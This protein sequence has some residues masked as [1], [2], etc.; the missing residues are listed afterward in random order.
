MASV[1]VATVERLGLI[2]LL[3]H[4]HAVRRSRL[5]VPSRPLGAERTAHPPGRRDVEPIGI[6]AIL[7][8]R[9]L[10]RLAM[11]RG[12]FDE[13]AQRLAPLAPLA[14]RATDIQFICPVQASLAELA[15]WEGRPDDALQRLLAAIPPDR[16]LARGP[17]R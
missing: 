8:P 17:A 11:V 5:P 16:L 7:V 2:A 6:N 9:W 13:A 1:G 4:A 10:A 12:R 14:A 15:L 3:R